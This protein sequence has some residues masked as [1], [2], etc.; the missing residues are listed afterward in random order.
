MTSDIEIYLR[1]QEPTLVL[2]RWLG[3]HFINITEL[4]H[5]GKSLNYR[6]YYSGHP[7]DFQLFPHAAGKQ[8]MCV[9]F[10]QQKDTP[11]KD[12]RDCAADAFHH[13]NIESRCIASH[14]QEADGLALEDSANWL[15]FSDQGEEVIIW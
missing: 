6:G 15:K 12:D 4:T 14:W 8:F 13:L 5:R 1:C 9:S 11:W 3:H 10:Q 2:E 7:C